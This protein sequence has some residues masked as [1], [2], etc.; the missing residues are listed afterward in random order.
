MDDLASRQFLDLERV[1]WWFEGRRRVFFALLHRH[2][3]KRRNLKILDVG[4]G[5]GGMMRE[6]RAFGEPAGLEIS[7]P[8]LRLAKERGFSRVLCGSA[9][10]L[11]VRDRSIDLV[12]AFDC[13]EHLD[14]DQR[15]LRAF[16]RALHPDGH[17]F[18]SVPAYQFLYAEND[19]VAQHKRRYTRSGLVRKLREAGFEV[20]RATYV[21]ALLFPV[22]LPAVL[23]LKVRQRLFPRP[24]E[25]N[26]SYMPGGWMNRLLATVFGGERHLL[27]FANFPAGH[28]IA[29]LARPASA[30]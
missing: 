18:L 10:A 1:H 19:R 24:P 13:I 17:V 25:T 12:T 7:L 3:P 20:V 21:N 30:G 26:L 28:S 27:R 22:I 23:G 5:V 2:L 11:P 9:D 16:H 29:V 8:M 15:A 14:D 4:C 6:L